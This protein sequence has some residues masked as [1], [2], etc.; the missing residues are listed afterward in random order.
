MRAYTDKRYLKPSGNNFDLLI[1]MRDAVAAAGDRD[2]TVI[3]IKAHAT[4]DDVVK[5]GIERKHLVGNYI[6]DEFAKMAA[7]DVAALEGEQRA[8][9]IM[10][11][12][13]WLLQDR[14]VRTA[15]AAIEQSKEHQT[16]Y[17]RRL[18]SQCKR[19]ALEADAEAAGHTIVRRGNL[20]RCTMCPATAGRS[21]LAKL[22]LQPC[23]RILC[24]EGDADVPTSRIGTSIM[25][26][27]QAVH[28]SHHIAQ[29]RGFLWCWRCG[30]FNHIVNTLKAHPRKLAKPCGPPTTAQRQYLARLRRGQPPTCNHVWERNRG[31]QP[32]PTDPFANEAGQQG[33]AHG[34]DDDVLEVI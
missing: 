29:W 18:K 13:T 21:T 2:I 20:F 1:E 16:L 11:G 9:E 27:N 19:K 23:S 10:D 6:V 12:T 8:I 25:I 33:N 5:Y 32:W 3:W 4:A 17:P 34:P 24:S 31:R 15:L 7:K 14:L 28:A 22:C 26:G 30:C